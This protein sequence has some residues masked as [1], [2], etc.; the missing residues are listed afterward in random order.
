MKKLKLSGKDIRRVGIRHPEAISIAKNELQKHYK[1]SS[2]KE[3]QGVLKEV[4]N[5][6]ESFLKDEKLSK[7]AQKL[8]Q[9]PKQEKPKQQSV[10]LQEEGTF[11]IFGK[12]FID[13][14]AL[15]QMYTAMK[16]P[17]A[18]KGAIMPDAHQGYGLPI[19]GVL[20]TKNTVLPFGVGIDIGCRMAL[21]I[22]PLE[23][24]VINRD[25]KNLKNILMENT[26]F[27]RAEFKESKEHP[28]FER[29]EFKEISFL[30][31]LR[32]KTFEQLGTS[33]HGN[34]FVDIGILEISGKNTLSG[35]EP[36]SYL[37][38][39][40]HSGSRGLG[41]EI[42][43]HYTSLAREKLNLPKGAKQLI[44]FDLD[45]EEGQEYWK[46]MNLAGDYSAANHDFIHKKLSKALGE[47]PLRRIENHHNYAWREKAKDG[48]TWIVHRK[49]ATPAG[50]GDI[51]VIPGSMASPAFVVRGKGLGSSLNSAAH[52]AGRVMSRTKAKKTYTEKQLKKVLSDKG[53]ELIGGSPDEAPMVYKDIHK[54]MEL[55]QDMVEIV[56]TFYPKIV[57]ME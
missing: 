27:G 18:V 56:A 55:Q 28:L 31:S 45:S 23:S 16:L 26:R 35:V 12:D 52:G 24:R 6:P 20:A 42:A 1:H 49:G 4:L 13:S 25:V 8:Y 11:E 9:P 32:K 15:E 7:I 40:S 46:A 3:V 5:A 44:W 53:I 10:D 33:G 36:G 34:H 19:G 14:S 51:G 21:S 37:A 54:V 17:V 43:R 41:A 48:S 57:R 38:V 30:K 2:K 50:R 47:Q 29:S 39:L 22:Y